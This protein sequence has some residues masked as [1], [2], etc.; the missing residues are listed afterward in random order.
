MSNTLTANSKSFGYPS[1][2]DIQRVTLNIDNDASYFQAISLLVN[3]GGLPTAN[4]KAG[5]TQI[6]L[7]DIYQTVHSGY[8]LGFTTAQ[9]STL[10][11]KPLVDVTDLFSDTAQIIHSVLIDN[12]GGTVHFEAKTSTMKI[13][14]SEVSSVDVEG[15]ALQSPTRFIVRDSDWYMYPNSGLTLSVIDT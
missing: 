2:I 3:G 12:C 15:G 8:K 4:F 13:I 5:G 11:Q 6:I 7:K 14:N 10:Y 9:L 1:K